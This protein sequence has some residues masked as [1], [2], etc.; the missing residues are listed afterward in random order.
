MDQTRKYKLLRSTLLLPLYADD[1][2]DYV[3]VI[4]IVLCM[5]LTEWI[6][7]RQWLVMYTNSTKLVN[8]ISD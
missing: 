5:K 8:F 3:V 7:D 1:D 4:R 6:E 2:D